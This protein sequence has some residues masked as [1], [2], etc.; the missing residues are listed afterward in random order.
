MLRSNLA[1]ILT[2]AAHFVGASGQ[3]FGGAK[4]YLGPPTQIFGGAMAP[5]P[6]PQF[7]HPCVEIFAATNPRFSRFLPRH[8]RDFYDFCRDMPRFLRFLRHRDFWP[9][10]PRQVKLK[11]DNSA[12]IIGQTAPAAEEPPKSRLR[13]A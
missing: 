2:L 1:K 10:K 8:C 9:S 13:T 4:A 7:R 3:N 12:Y 6:P 5:L 11:F